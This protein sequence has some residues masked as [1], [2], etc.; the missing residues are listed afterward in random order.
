MKVQAHA[1]PVVCDALRWCGDAP[2][3]PRW[4]RVK[5]RRAEGVLDGRDEGMRL[6]TAHGPAQLNR[7]D[8][9]LREPN[10]G[11]VWPVRNED[12]RTNFEIL[13]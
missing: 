3:L 13:V 4:L 12:F 10:T 2:G 5:L 11:S 7:G 1:K 9:V 6:E 8:W